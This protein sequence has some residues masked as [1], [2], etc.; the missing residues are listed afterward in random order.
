MAA[1]TRAAALLA[2]ALGPAWVSGAGPD[3]DEAAVRAHFAPFT[4][5]WM[6]GDAAAVAAGYAEDADIVRPEQP[7]VAG[8]PAIQAFYERMFAGPLKGV[9]K[10]MRV[11]RVRLVTEA[12]AVVDASYTLDREEP[13]LHAKGV[14]LTVLQKR[15]G[16]WAT[17][18]SRSYRLP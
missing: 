8:R 3:G 6:K 9:A 5:A 14:S 15:D 13:A 12:L 16:R 4:D 2:I 10:T 1:N 11:D 7:P 18:V 17:V